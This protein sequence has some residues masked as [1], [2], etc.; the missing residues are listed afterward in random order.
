MRLGVLRTRT[1][2]IWDRRRDVANIGIQLVKCEVRI[3]RGGVASAREAFRAERS[4]RAIVA[5]GSAPDELARIIERM[6][7]RSAGLIVCIQRSIVLEHLLESAG[8]DCVFHIGAKRPD[9]AE[10]AFH[11][12]VTIDGL[13]LADNTVDDIGSYVE[14]DST[15]LPGSPNRLMR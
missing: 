4:D 13:P 8:F 15:S 7:H 12:W 5:S 2:F 11:A 3:R 10:Y 1:R 6:G 9:G 14:F